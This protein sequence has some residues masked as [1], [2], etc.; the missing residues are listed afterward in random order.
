MIDRCLYLFILIDFFI[1]K[2][3]IFSLNSISSLLQPVFYIGMTDRFTL[4]FS[5]ES[6]Q[7]SP[8]FQNS[9][10]KP[11]TALQRWL[12]MGINQSSVHVYKVPGK[13]QQK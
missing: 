11:P 9:K 5:K 2:Q 10:T 6:C 12:S 8:A 1:F 13:L 7:T 3:N 4:L